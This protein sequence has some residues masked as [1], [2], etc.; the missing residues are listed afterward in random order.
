M[1]E[2]GKEV[3][4]GDSLVIVNGETHNAQ[5][6]SMTITTEVE[7]TEMG[8]KISMHSK[9]VNVSVEIDLEYDPEF[10]LA[11]LQYAPQIIQEQ[12]ARFIEEGTRDG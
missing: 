6:R 2:M 3:P 5:V 1:P 8:I 7:L 4:E 10:H 12:V 11:M 9:A